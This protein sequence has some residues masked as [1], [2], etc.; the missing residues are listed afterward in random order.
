[1]GLSQTMD[2]TCLE[3]CG[4]KTDEDVKDPHTDVTFSHPE[5]KNIYIYD[6]CWLPEPS[7]SVLSQSSQ[8][9]L[10]SGGVAKGMSAIFRH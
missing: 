1:M 2:S 4:D 8:T 10:S 5:E 7:Q 6:H 9:F 3:G